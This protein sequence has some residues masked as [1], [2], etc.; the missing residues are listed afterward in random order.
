MTSYKIKVN[1]AWSLAEGPFE[2]WRIN[3]KTGEKEFVEKSEIAAI[4]DRLDEL[5]TLAKA[6][7]N[8]ATRREL[9]LVSCRAQAAAHSLIPKVLPPPELIKRL[10]NRIEL[11]SVSLAELK[12]YRG[13]DNVG[14]LNVSFGGGKL[15][16]DFAV[17]LPRFPAVD[18]VDAIVIINMQK[19]LNSLYDAI[20]KLPTGKP[21]NVKTTD[22]VRYAIEFSFYNSARKPAYTPKNPIRDFVP[23]FY[24]W[25]TGHEAD[26]R[27]FTGFIR[28]ALDDRAFMAQLRRGAEMRLQV[29][30]L[31]SST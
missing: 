10:K 27:G 8:D 26:G 14:D 5:L 30:R 4:K 18:K 31:K 29:S 7:K 23:A 2:L 22:I 28:K 13:G 12:K 9:Y 21:E 20:K 6:K 25:I 15:V 16:D 17:A 19:L 3:P 24:E 11:T 1:E